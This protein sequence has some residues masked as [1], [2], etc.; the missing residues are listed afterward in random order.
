MLALI[1]VSSTLVVAINSAPITYDQRQD[2]SL[3]VHAKLDNILVVFAT[4][5]G[6]LM[7]LATQA[8]TLQ[9]FGSREDK[10]DA[11]S[12]TY[13]PDEITLE[14]NKEPY[15]VEIVGIQKNDS[16]DE[17]QIEIKVEMKP[18]NEKE[19][20]IAHHQGKEEKEANQDN[21][22]HTVPEENTERKSR[23]VLWS[24]LNDP[25]D[26]KRGMSLKK[27]LS[28][29]E[30]HTIREDSGKSGEHNEVEHAVH[31]HQELKLLGGAIE[32]CGPGRYRNS[33]GICQFE[34]SVN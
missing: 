9:P 20:L 6:A 4:S 10:D 7:D 23:N 32:N 1:L 31:K 17:S 27:E 30:I 14:N 25:E 24:R 11:V 18:E 2:G 12:L 29:K 26:N 21:K 13:K 28:S 5:S 8:L 15:R 33:Y 19:V 34:E 3:N 16:K 22:D